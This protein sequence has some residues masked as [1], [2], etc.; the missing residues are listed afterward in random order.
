MCEWESACKWESACH[1][2]RERE[3]DFAHCNACLTMRREALE[4]IVV[5]GNI[6][7][8]RGRVRLI[9]MLLGGLRQWRGWISSINRINLEHQGP[10]VW[11]DRVPT[12]LDK[13]HDDDV[14]WFTTRRWYCSKHTEVLP[15]LGKVRNCFRACTGGQPMGRNIVVFLNLFYLPILLICHFTVHYILF[16]C[17]CCFFWIL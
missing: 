1:W 4:Y 16:I 3:R 13:A 5:P 6:R 14:T 8:R 15:M 2:V 9:E 10:R 12:L 17:C 7:G 11:R